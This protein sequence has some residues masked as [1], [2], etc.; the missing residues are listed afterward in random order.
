MK[1]ELLSYLIAT[2]EI[3]DFLGY[4]PKCPYCK[5]KLNK[6]KKV[7]NDNVIYYCNNCKRGFNKELTKYMDNENT[8]E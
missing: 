8:F 4:E 6:K 5:I 1:D 3:D 2:D 7:N